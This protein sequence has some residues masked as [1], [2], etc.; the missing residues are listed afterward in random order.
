MKTILNKLLNINLI[1]AILITLLP[2]N[3]N[4]LNSK[5]GIVSSTSGSGIV[6]RSGP[7]VTYDRVGGFEDGRIVDIIEE[8]KPTDNSKDKCS[9][10]YK[11][12]YSVQAYVCADLIKLVEIVENPTYNFQEELKKFPDS[13]KS[14]IKK[15]HE[16]Y[17]NA[18]FF[19]VSTTNTNGSKM[20]FKTAVTNE[21]ILGKSL[22]WDRFP[23]N[24]RDGLKNLDS[25][26][27]SNNSFNNNYPGGGK[28]WYAA[29]YNTI[30]Y[31]MDPRNFLN[32]QRIFMF[33]SQS[34]NPNLHT[35]SG[36]E[37]ILKGSYMASS[38]VDNSDKTFAEAIM[39]A[40]IY[41]NV[42]PY[43][44]AS[45]ILQEVGLTRSSLVLGTYTDY[46]EFNGYYNYYNIGA[47]GNNIV[48]NGLK[49]A[50]ESG[51]NS[52]YKA[53]VYGSSWIG[54]NYISSGQ[55]TGYFQKWDV[56]CSGNRSCYSH[57]YMQNIEAPFSESLNTYNAY[58]KNSESMYL[59][60]YVFNIPI[61]ENMVETKLPTE[62]SPINYLSSLIVDKSMINNFDS[63]TYEYNL[64]IPY[65]TN[66]IN[67]EATSY[68]NASIS[69][70]GNINITK[71]K[72]DVIIKVT[73]L[74]GDVRY[75]TIHVTREKKPN[76]N[77][78]TLDEAIAKIKNIRFNNNTISG[79]TSI[80]TLKAKI[81]ESNTGINV[82]V[83][84]NKGEIINTGS[85]GTGYKVTFS[86]NNETKKYDTIIYGDNNGDGEI[87]ILDL[88]RVQKQL[89]KSINLTGVEYASCDVNK[90]G[91]VTILDLL[92]V[93][94][95]LLGSKFIN[96]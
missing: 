33:E 76:E 32:E 86:L 90:D 52:E 74:N 18:M 3:I 38:K 93:Q 14:Y 23:E 84:N 48:Y 24:Y 11:I 1:L 94:K 85:L 55:D 42:S 27:I 72:Q 37:A 12:N 57:Q 70:T 31:Y 58:K 95:H 25:Y 68:K 96:Q 39:D 62:K 89:L 71:D 91:N 77:K 13:Y 8:V 20:D 80:D 41:S 40:A 78:M 66:V 17:P 51:W 92:L 21:N 50:Y 45:R 30:A 82:S 22:I 9:K 36:I 19:A 63:T 34:Y 56:K 60:P 79:I 26:N 49:K 81:N 88:L 7:G 28:N 5:K 10:W 73:A 67:V 47:S 29:N 75:Y 83:Q 64:S 59:N 16:I 35:I 44:L 46:P 87:T 61:Y 43:F 69:G 53:I 4:A 65:N 54:N 2:Y 6:I 15:L